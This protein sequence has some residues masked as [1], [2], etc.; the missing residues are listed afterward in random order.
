MSY[1]IMTNSEGLARCKHDLLAVINGN[2]KTRAKNLSWRDKIAVRD[3]AGFP[4]PLAKGRLI[5]GDGIRSE[6]L[7]WFPKIFMSFEDVLS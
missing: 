5:E 2:G 7:S 1:L 4:S 3:I 6:G